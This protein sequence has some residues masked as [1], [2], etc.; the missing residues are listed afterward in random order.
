M[1]YT[2][3][4][5]LDIPGKLGLKRSTFEG[6]AFEYRKGMGKS[7]AGPLGIQGTVTPQKQV[8]LYFPPNVFE[9]MLPSIIENV[10]SV[11]VK[12]VY[13]P[14]SANIPDLLAIGFPHFNNSLSVDTSHNINYLG[15]EYLFFTTTAPGSHAVD[16]KINPPQAIM[17][18]RSTFTVLRTTLSL[19]DPVGNVPLTTHDGVYLWFDFDVIDW[20]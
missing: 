19:W 2:S 13:L 8:F 17:Q 5:D 1:N 14:Y 3:K 12:H 11:S 16:Y 20:Q 7:T 9:A 18:K 15:S 4:I 6:Q 10:I